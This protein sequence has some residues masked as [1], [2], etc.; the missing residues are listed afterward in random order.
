M[1]TADGSSI[2]ADGFSG[3]IAASSTV[4]DSVGKVVS[5]ARVLLQDTVEPYRYSTAELV[6]ALNIGILEARRLRP[7]L[8]VGAPYMMASYS[9]TSDSFDLDPMY[10]PSFV[11]YVA[12]RAQ[13][14]DDEPSQDQR[15]TVLMNKFIA[16]LLSISA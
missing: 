2:T 13:L 11:Y 6:E 16:Q 12:G 15:A 9:A 8:F 4:L 1:L 7:E 3:S 10:R 5:E 14:R